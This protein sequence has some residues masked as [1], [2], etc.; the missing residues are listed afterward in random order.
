MLTRCLLVAATTFLLTTRLGVAQ[1]T[2]KTTD[3]ELKRLAGEWR[4]VAA[5][6]DGA[7]AESRTVVRFAG[8]KATLSDPGTGLP[9]LELVVALDPAAT[10]P[11]MDLTNPQGR[12]QKGIYKLNGD[13]LRVVSQA[14]PAGPR[15]AAFG[16][17]KGDGRV[18][19]TY[20]LVKAK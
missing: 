4:V 20:Q 1:D 12:T 3:A 2:A 5:E 8:A 14:D 6:R 17:A 11:R 9:A 18:M 7:P 10:P 19:Y 16:T 15:P 13:T